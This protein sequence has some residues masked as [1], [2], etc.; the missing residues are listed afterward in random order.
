LQSLTDL[1]QFD[2]SFLLNAALC[3]VVGVDIAKL[4]ALVTELSVSDV[5][6]ATAVAIAFFET[7]LGHMQDDWSLLVNKARKWLTKTLTAAGSA[8]TIGQLVDRCVS[9]L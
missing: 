1:Q 6:V 8:T 3:G 9:A 7:K 4:Q 5:A 2:G